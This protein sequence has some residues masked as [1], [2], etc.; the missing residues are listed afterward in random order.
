MERWGSKIASITQDSAYK[1]LSSSRSSLIC[2]RQTQA[3]DKQGCGCPSRSSRPTNAL[4]Q[5]WVTTQTAWNAASAAALSNRCRAWMLS[6]L[7][8]LAEMAQLDCNESRLTDWSPKPKRR[9][10]GWFP[11]TTVSA[12]AGV[13]VHKE[14]FNR[15]ILQSATCYDSHLSDGVDNNSIDGCFEKARLK[16]VSGKVSLESALPR[17]T[18]FVLFRKTDNFIPYLD[19]R[20]ST[21]QPDARDCEEHQATLKPGC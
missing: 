3:H 5:P 8:T 2:Q 14:S 9:Q 10:Y 15:L 20:P 4:A 21:C 1:D 13:G 11:S 7:H 18:F 19:M 6:G 12:S 17:R 16:L